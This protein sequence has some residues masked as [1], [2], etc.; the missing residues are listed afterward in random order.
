MKKALILISALS[1]LM[2]CAQNLDIEGGDPTD[3]GKNPVGSKSELTISTMSNPTR[4]IIKDKKVPGDN[5]IGM[6]PRFFSETVESD[7]ESYN[8]MMTFGYDAERSVWRGITRAPSPLMSKGLMDEVQ[9]EVFMFNPFY[10]PGGDHVAMDYV[11]FSYYNLRETLLQAL[12]YY[13]GLTLPSDVRAIVDLVM[14][15]YPMIYNENRVDVWYQNTVLNLLSYALTM[16]FQS[17]VLDPYVVV[18]VLALSAVYEIPT[19]FE[20]NGETPMVTLADVEMLMPYLVEAI[21]K[22]R[23]KEKETAPAAEAAAGGEAASGEEGEVAADPAT[24]EEE[25]I[26]AEVK[27]VLMKFKGAASFV[28]DYVK[29]TRVIEKGLTLEEAGLTETAFRDAVNTAY[30]IFMKNLP[31]VSEKVQ[32]DLLYSNGRSLKNSGGP[33]QVTFNHAKAWVKVLVNNQTDNDIFISSLA[34]DKVKTGGALVMDNS[35]SGFEVYWDFLS[36]RP[37]KPE[38]EPEEP[39]ETEIGLTFES[40][41]STTL[42]GTSVN[43]LNSQAPAANQATANTDGKM[44]KEASDNP[45]D[46][47]NISQEAKEEI[48]KLF[49][50]GLIADTY[51]APAGCYGPAAQIELTGV[52]DKD[53][54]VAERR[55]KRM[56]GDEAVTEPSRLQLYCLSG[57]NPVDDKVVGL[58][59][60]LGGAM[61]PAQEPGTITLTYYPVLRDKKAIAIRQGDSAYAPR[62]AI[63]HD[64]YVVRDFEMGSTISYLYDNLRESDLQTVTLNLP[65][66]NWKMGK[67]YIYV[68]TI[69]NNEI[70]INGVLEKEWE[71]VVV[72][73]PAE[74]GLYSKDPTEEF[75]KGNTEGWF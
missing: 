57:S 36:E 9:D 65:R 72:T 48:A 42:D 70:T 8:Q 71:E 35:K 73:H 44:A 31:L 27:A 64:G 41:E 33:I 62:E 45:L 54:E 50:M 25:E 34:F 47:L 60:N 5:F 14:D 67:A 4:A 24:Q 55:A 63:T 11:A 69:T 49:T 10:W 46:R 19:G 51:L 12:K 75:E 6:L 18:T 21:A 1:L 68:I 43:V 59:A 56:D 28:K 29:A 7:Y 53:S 15:A 30:Y 23:E 17:P 39:E 32:D 22:A 66:Q 74:T 40:Y 61:F 13:G 38:E 2:S 16:S 26:P 20:E 37:E 3:P 58:A 52:A